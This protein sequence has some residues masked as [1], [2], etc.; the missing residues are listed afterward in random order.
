MA[1]NNFSMANSLQKYSGLKEENLEFFLN[2]LEQ[3]SEIEK[4]DSKKKT[5]IL[6][7]NLSGNALRVVSESKT[8]VDNEYEDIVK[9]LRGKFSRHISYA[10]I[11][12]KFNSLMQKPNQNIRSLLEEVETIT[13]DYLD[14]GVNSSEE[15]LKL[16][17]KM[18]SQKLLDSMRPD[19]RIEVMKRGAT[20]F[21]N[22]GKIAIDVE[23][24]LSISDNHVNSITKSSEIEILLKNQIE[25][26]KKIEELTRKLDELTKTKAV[27]NVVENQANESRNQR[28]TCHIC[29]KLH[30]TTDCWYYPKNE[31]NNQRYVPYNR[32]NNGNNF[33][34]GYG[35]QFRNRNNFRRRG[36]RQNN[37]N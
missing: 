5:L 27:N 14:I 26:N 31:Y 20:E 21:K 8:S 18:K 25:S 32:N 10:E 4:W 7:L 3:I 37:L 29:N 13:N 15:T 36:G 34:R 22:I 33:R 6:K 23:N 12:G 1:K 17:A 28:V 24:A 35:R 16:A 11:Q 9:L 2:N 19:I 30:K